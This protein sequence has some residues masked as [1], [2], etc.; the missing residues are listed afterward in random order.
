MSLSERIF[1]IVENKERH[2][3]FISEWEQEFVDSIQKQVKNGRDSL[4]PAQNSILQKIEAK[5]SE[6]AIAAR[7]T[8]ASTWSQEKQ[9]VA[10]IVAKYYLYAGYFTTAAERVISDPEWIM[11]EALYGKM[12][13]N[14]YAKKV[15]AETAADPK[16]EVGATVML[17]TTAPTTLFSWPD[18]KKLYRTPLFVMGISSEIKNAVKGAKIYTILPAGHPST[19][20]VEERYLKKYRQ[21]KKKDKIIL[22][23]EIPF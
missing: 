8:W 6:D 1:N 14:K 3:A 4:S 15:L 11:P 20:E 21:S 13:H 5:L 23:K 16:F 17:R 10:R 12:C 2:P 9:K 22:D 18:R 7:N 19:F